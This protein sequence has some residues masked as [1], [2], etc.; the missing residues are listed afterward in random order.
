MY[1]F[2]DKVEIIAN[3]ISEQ[4][5]FHNKSNFFEARKKHNRTNIGGIP[6][7]NRAVWLRVGRLLLERFSK[8]NATPKT[9]QWQ[10]QRKNGVEMAWVHPQ[11]E[12]QAILTSALTPTMDIQQ[13][14]IQTPQLL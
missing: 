12:I 13:C 1:G 8:D 3:Y 5:S 6:C 14:P 9:T 7:M 11:I 10:R 4:T 2:Y